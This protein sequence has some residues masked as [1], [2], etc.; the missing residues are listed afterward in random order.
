MIF[1]VA[2]GSALGGAARYSLGGLIQRAAPG[3]FPLGTLVINVLGSFVLG[4]I[5]RYAMATPA[6]S[7]EARAFLTIGLCGGFTTFSTFSY[8]S[9]MLMERGE[10]SRLALYVGLSLLLTLAGVV[11]GG[12]LAGQALTLRRSI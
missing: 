11:A 6:V 10:W 1:W 4:F 9:A 7:T 2:F 8:E 12:A 5:V 3:G